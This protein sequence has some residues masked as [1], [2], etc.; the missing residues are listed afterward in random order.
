MNGSGS[1]SG[2][3]WGARLLIAFVLILAGAAA[4]VWSLARYEPAARFFGI[5][6]TPR[7][8]AHVECSADTRARGAAGRDP[9]ADSAQRTNCDARK[10]GGAG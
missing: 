3:G 4:T 5:S 8:R 9:R 10:P 7:D 6:Q 2:M 1:R